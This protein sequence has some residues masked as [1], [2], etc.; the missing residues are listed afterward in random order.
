MEKFYNKL[1][2]DNIPKIIEEDGEIPIYKTLDNN[3]YWESLIKKDFEELEE[4]KNAKTS[5]EVKKELADKLEVIMAMAE[6][7][8][9]ILQD[10]IN[11]SDKKRNRNGGFQ[12]RLFLEKTITKE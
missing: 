11:E 7:Q 1:V 2:R 5:E 3:A 4:V 10:I 9:F 12:K 6:F 8:G